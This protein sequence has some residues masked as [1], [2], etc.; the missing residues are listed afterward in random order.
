MI[1]LD[2]ALRLLLQEVATL[3]RVESGVGDARL[4]VL[5]EDVLADR[6]YPPSDRSAMEP[7]K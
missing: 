1:D 5:A 6:D 3:G 7:Q 2:E 4:A